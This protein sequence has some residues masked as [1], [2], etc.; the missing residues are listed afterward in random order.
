MEDL[1]IKMI[2]STI[3]P[4]TWSDMGGPGTIE[5]YPLGLALVITQTPDIQEQVAELLASLRRLQDLQVTVEVRFIT[6]DEAF[7]E[8]IGLDFNLN[9]VTPTN[10]NQ[11]QLISGQFQPFGFDNRFTPSE[12]PLRTAAKQ[13]RAGT[14]RSDPGSEHPDHHFQLRPGGATVRRL[15]WR[16]WR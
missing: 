10:S 7:Y 1:L 13:W 14:R 16:D 9:V 3:K 8:R 12:L 11:P 2:T 6:I 15:P 5:Y 4:E